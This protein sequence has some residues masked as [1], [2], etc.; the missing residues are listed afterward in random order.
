MSDISIGFLDDSSHV[1]CL[2]IKFLR[3]L[4]I[5]LLKCTIWAKFGFELVFLC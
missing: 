3:T 1:P 2:P 5:M 4:Y